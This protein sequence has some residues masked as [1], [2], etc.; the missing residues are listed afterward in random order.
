[1][2]TESKIRYLTAGR[3]VKKPFK[4]DNDKFT[5]LVL[6]IAR[7]S[8]GDPRFGGVKLNKLLFYA[9][10]LSYVHFG[11]PMTG[12]QYA[13][14]A[15]GPAPKY[16]VPLWRKMLQNKD[17]AVRKAPTPLGTDQE[18]TL[19]LREA[20]LSKFTAQEVDLVSKLIQICWGKSGNYLREA[21][22]KFAGW[23]LAKEKE[24]IPYSVALVG[25]RK[26]TPLEIA[27]GLSLETS[28][29]ACL[30]QHAATAS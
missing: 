10:F 6:F 11:R 17:I 9:D 24:T 25:S 4:A 22:H 3:A 20:D 21:T 27:R 7:R 23:E 12:Q 28:A 26:P 18:T 8:E 1:M 13:A 19:A 5:E 14:L 2:R 15:N 16:K 30:A 29:V